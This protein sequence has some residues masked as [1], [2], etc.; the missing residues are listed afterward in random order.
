MAKGKLAITVCTNCWWWLIP[1]IK[2]L[3]MIN[4]RGYNHYLYIEKT[5]NTYYETQGNNNSCYFKWL[6]PKRFSLPV[7][8][9]FVLFLYRTKPSPCECQWLQHKFHQHFCSMGPSSSGTS[10]WFY[11]VLHSNLQSVTQRFSACSVCGCAS[12]SNY[13]DES[14]WLHQLQHN[15]VCIYLQRSW[16]CQCTYLCF[17]EWRQ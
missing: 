3:M 2:K 6:F 7:F 5:K 1:G 4:Q 9:I 12:K 13:V 15:G 16:K 10:K 17:H 8:K 14:K 11:I